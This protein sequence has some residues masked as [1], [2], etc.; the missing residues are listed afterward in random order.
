[1]PKIEDPSQY[2][3]I[4]LYAAFLPFLKKY[5]KSK[6]KVFSKNVPLSVVIDEI[7]EE[8]TN[9]YEI[10]NVVRRWG[11]STMSIIIELA[12]KGVLKLPSLRPREKFIK[13]FGGIIKKLFLNKFQKVDGY[14]FKIIEPKPY[15]VILLDEYDL[16]KLLKSKMTREDMFKNLNLSKKF[17]KFLDDRITTLK[18]GQPA[19]GNIDITSKFKLVNLSDEDLI[20]KLRVQVNQI[21]KENNLR[22]EITRTSY[23][24][25]KTDE[26]PKVYVDLVGGA[27]SRRRQNEGTIIRGLEKL[28]YNTNF[29]RVEY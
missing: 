9:D 16:D 20:K 4:D 10:Q 21:I 6:G 22:G 27:W 15:E 3:A 5:I 14:S 8:L 12:K 18:Q 24:V 26:G 11:D 28:G 19:L 13:K 7:K 17:Q 23:K 29:M 2:N 25:Q 1:M